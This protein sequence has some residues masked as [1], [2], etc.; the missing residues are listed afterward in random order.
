MNKLHKLPQEL[1]NQIAAGEVIER[2]SSVVKELVDN[3]I[4][5]KATKITIKLENGGIDLIEISDNGS[6]IEKEALLEIFEPHTTSKISTLDDLNTLLTMGF[7]GEA[8]STIQS[9]A[10]VS[11]TSKQEG[12][13]SGSTLELSSKTVKSAPREV[14]TTISVRKIFD[15]IPARKKFLKTH[16]TEYR[17]I[18]DILLRYFIQFPNIHFILIK[19]QKEVYNLP[20]VS[21]TPEINK[22]RV[23]AVIKGGIFSDSIQIHSDGAGIKI[24]GVVAHPNRKASRTAHQYIFVN[25]RGVWDSGV[26][27]AVLQGFSRYIPHGSKIPFIVSIDIEPNLVDVNVHPRKEEVRFINPYRIFSAV[28][29]AVSD[30]LNRSISAKTESINI[31]NE[32]SETTENTQQSFDTF[33]PSAQYSNPKELNFSKRGKEYSVKSG[34]KFSQS[35]LKDEGKERYESTEQFKNISQ[36]F[37]KYIFVEFENDLWVIDQHAA[38]ERIT[39]EKLERSLESESKD[40]QNLLVPISIEADPSQLS[41]TSENIQFFK[42]LGF[43]IE[44][45]DGS[46]EISSIPAFLNVS[47]AQNVFENI[48]KLDIEDMDMKNEFEKA[49][50]D[51]FATIACH[52]SIRSGQAL[53]QEECIGVFVQLQQCTN[54]YSCPHGRPIIWKMKLS[55]IDTNFDRTY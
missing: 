31:S 52:S 54:Q 45:K 44:I 19:D 27:R 3:S 24:S 11:V 42:D 34:L 4:D 41:F 18:L 10:Q 12:S 36:M 53:S 46:I 28:E 9:I 20:A 8:L 32:K 5:A 39:F 29:N 51:I 55:E 7:R 14:G 33:T 15:Q 26:A 37:N 1:I 22:E 50:Q 43:D 40:I 6:G 47:S 48:W 2:P 21:Q 13:Q 23:D 49:K 17:K 16:E 38:A 35:I 30:A 25:R